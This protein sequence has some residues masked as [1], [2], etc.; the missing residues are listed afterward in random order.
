[1]IDR[2]KEREKHYHL[3]N[4][5]IHEKYTTNIDKGVG[6][7]KRKAESHTQTDNC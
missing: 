3:T 1:M 4:V 6:V 5:N 7:D 2:E